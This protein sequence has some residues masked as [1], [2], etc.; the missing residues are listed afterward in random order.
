M[1]SQLIQILC[2]EDNVTDVLLLQESLTESESYTFELTNYQ[3]LKKGLHHLQDKEYDVILLDLGL[4]DSQG[5]RTLEQ[6]G[7][8][9]LN[10]HRGADRTG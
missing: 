10:P 3:R 2:I 4:P 8:G 5:L 6:V 7:S 1:T 9:H